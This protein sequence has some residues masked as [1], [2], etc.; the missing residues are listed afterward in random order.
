M[1]Q[2]CVVIILILIV[3]LGVSC[4]NQDLNEGA[5]LVLNIKDLTQERSITPRSDMLK[6]SKFSVSGTGPNGATF[7]P[8]LSSESTI[9]VSDLATGKWQINA[10]ALNIENN[11]I[12]TGSCYQKI[13]KGKNNVTVNLDSCSGYGTLKIDFSWQSNIS[14][15][16]AITICVETQDSSGNIRQDEKSVAIKEEKT[17]ILINLPS[18][19]YT[20][21]IKIKDGSKSQEVG[22]EEELRIIENTLSEGSVVLNV[23][24]DDEG[25]KTESLSEAIINMIGTPVTCYIDYSP[26]FIRKGQSVVLKA[27]C[28]NLGKNIKEEELYYQWFKDGVLLGSTQKNCVIYSEL[29][30]HRYDLIVKSNVLGT[31]S[32]AS[33]VLE[34]NY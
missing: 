13:N 27:I 20:M 24:M 10:S 12:A 2:K 17:S 7:G 28:E 16:E 34:V 5:S 32:S 9:V 15:S 21:R 8:V 33:I 29:G 25:E 19:S 31:L 23:V 4:N 26:K 22:S 11:E 1:K 18:G 6:I 3:A 30:I 14:K